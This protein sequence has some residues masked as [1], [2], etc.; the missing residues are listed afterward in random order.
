MSKT[1]HLKTKPD[2]TIKLTN[3]D[4]TLSTV[5][6]YKIDNLDI[7][8]ETGIPNNTT[9]KNI[10]GIAGKEVIIYKTKVY[11]VTNHHITTM[12]IS[13]NLETFKT[14]IHHSNVILK[15]LFDNA[16]IISNRLVITE[17]KITEGFFL[18]KP[19]IIFAYEYLMAKCFL[20]N[21]HVGAAGLG[22]FKK[23]PVYGRGAEPTKER[24]LNEKV[25]IDR[26][27]YLTYYKS[28]FDSCKFNKTIKFTGDANISEV[29]LDKLVCLSYDMINNY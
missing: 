19:L 2:G 17:E 6:I 4:I 3:S 12:T 9:I 26:D 14:R 20:T 16:V 15:Y 24:K 13:D 28:Y 21:T 11:L 1:H 7:M 25:D 10:Q 18:F 27:T 22:E 23:L 8:K 29:Q 5:T